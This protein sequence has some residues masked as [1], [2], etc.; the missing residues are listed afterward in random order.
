MVH[1]QFGQLTQAEAAERLGV[2][3]TKISRTIQSL[4][5]RSKHCSP[6]RIMFPILTEQQYAVYQCVIEAGMTNSQTA[7]ELNIP[8]ASVGNTLTTLRKKGMSV[9]KR[10]PVS[11]YY[12]DMADQVTNKF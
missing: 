7:V 9:P 6:I 1:H 10:K 4:I 5:E 12:D 2:S 11:T 3:E 8:V